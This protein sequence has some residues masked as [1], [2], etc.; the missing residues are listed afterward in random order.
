MTN[1]TKEANLPPNLHDL[2]TGVLKGDR[3]CLAKAI[4]LAESYRADHRIAAEQVMEYI[5]KHKTDK[6]KSIR[7]GIT[8][9][10]GA[11]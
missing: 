11:G 10:P 7:I 8:G 9:P 2:V 6:L 4:T 5:N 3:Q 1:L